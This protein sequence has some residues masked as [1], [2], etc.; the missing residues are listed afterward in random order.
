[1]VHAQLVRV[2]AQ[3]CLLV[4]GVDHV[5]VLLP[6][7]PADLL[8][9]LGQTDVLTSDGQHQL[10]WADETSPQ[11]ERSSHRSDRFIHLMSF[12]MEQTNTGFDVTLLTSGPMSRLKADRCSARAT[13]G[14]GL[15]LS[16]LIKPSR[17]EKR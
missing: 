4:V 2:H 14:S 7:G 15:I 12:L 9:T 8:F 1:M 11:H 6:D 5:H 3:R 17:A 16:L 10:I 13:E